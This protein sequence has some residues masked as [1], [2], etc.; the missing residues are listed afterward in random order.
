M[1]KPSVCH[2]TS[3]HQQFDIRIFR[4]QLLS[5]K[6]AGYDVYQISQGESG[7]RKGIKLIGLGEVPKSRL[8]RILF[9]TKKIYKAALKLDSDIY[10]VHDPELL[11]AAAKL[12]KRGKIVI[13]DSHENVTGQIEEK[14]YIPKLFRKI[15]AK[16]YSVFEKNVLKKLSGVICV[17]PNFTQRM[18]K[19]N[20]NCVTVT[21][22]PLLSEQET[23]LEKLSIDN[24]SNFSETSDKVFKICFP[25]L[26]SEEWCHLELLT[27][28]KDI[29]LEYVLCGPAHKDYFEEMKKHPAW[30]KV[31][32]QGIVSRAQVRTSI[33]ESN[34]GMALCRKLPNTDYDIGTLGNTKLF[35]YMLQ[36]RPVCCTNFILWE[37]IVTKYNCGICIEP[38]QPD[39]IEET[40]Q[41]FI[42]HPEEAKQM[43]ER[44]YKAVL[45]EYNWSTQEKT[46][47]DF[48]SKLQK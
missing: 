30:K 33:N 32:Y 11:P 27:A 3:V 47:L 8:K 22:Y 1:I 26:I 44:G 38:D 6:K 20:E 13:F 16:V 18:K 31:N 29:E 37:E 25:G 10:H 46:L 34:L 4:K 39:Q 14:T 42:K 19:Q 12:A 36:K 21:N 35:E 23:A 17:S 28:I 43:G 15:I 2:L 5:L 41:W 45:N 9:F 7:I 24:K 48:Y 40:I